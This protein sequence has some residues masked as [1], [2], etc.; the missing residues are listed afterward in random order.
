[1]RCCSAAESRC[2]V[3]IQVYTVQVLTVTPGATSTTPLY[4]LN[5]DPTGNYMVKFILPGAIAVLGFVEFLIVAGFL[6]YA[7][8]KA[9]KVYNVCDLLQSF[10]VYHNYNRGTTL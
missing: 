10:T 3:I 4:D 7:C 9:P 6:I 8:G 1:M 2:T 5:N